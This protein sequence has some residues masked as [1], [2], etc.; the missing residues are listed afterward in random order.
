[1]LVV[2]APTAPPK[3]V[4]PEPEGVKQAK[5]KKKRSRPA[6]TEPT[7]KPVGEGEEEREIIL[8][9]GPEPSPWLTIESAGQLDRKIV[10]HE[11]KVGDQAKPAGP[12]AESE[13]QADDS[14]RAPH[15]GQTDNT[16]GGSEVAASAPS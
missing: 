7:P 8:D 16:V 10:G 14:D 3:E 11:F 4:E 15:I 6:W 5:K 9:L 2:A 13:V 12:Q 1:M